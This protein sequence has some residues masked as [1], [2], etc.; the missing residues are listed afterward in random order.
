MRRVL[1][2]S[3]EATSAKGQHT[4]PCGDCPWRRDA[5]PGWLGT[6]TAA[7]WV[8]VAH[9]DDAIACH[10]KAG[11]QCA[12]A[13]I[14]RRNVVKSPRDPEALRLPANRETVFGT[15]IEF[16]THHQDPAARDRKWQAIVAARKRRG[17]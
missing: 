10:T 14:Y 16:T 3:N 8:K 12:G 17:R 5:L 1:V 13:A 7:E 2:S 11:A 9:G 6:L 15:P 4:A